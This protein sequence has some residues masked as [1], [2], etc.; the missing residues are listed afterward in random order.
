MAS[1]LVF[2]KRVHLFLG[3]GLL[4]FRVLVVVVL[5]FV[6]GH[7]HVLIRGLRVKLSVLVL[8]CRHFPFKLFD[9]V[10]EILLL[11]MHESYLLLKRLNELRID[12]VEKDLFKFS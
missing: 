1:S 3:Q 5:S 9:S 7:L 4:D 6:F 2:K 11:L 12:V 8:N 10:N